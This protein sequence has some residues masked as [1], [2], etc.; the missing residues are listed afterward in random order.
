MPILR[1]CFLFTDIEGSTRLWEHFGSAMPAAYKRHDAILRSV[2]A[3]HGGLVFKVIGDA[4]QVAFSSP[5]DGLNAAHDAQQLLTAAPW[6]VDGLPNPLRVRMALHVASIAPDK[7]GDFRSPELNR[8]GRLLSTAHGGQIVL[9]QGMEA[10]LRGSLPPELTLSDCGPHRLKDLSQPERIFQLVAPGL[11]Q[12]FP[13]L[14][15]VDSRPNNLPTLPTELIGRDYELTAIQSHFRNGHRMVTLLG[16]GGI[17]KTHLALVAG[18]RVL[19]EISERVWFAGLDTARDPELVPSAIATALSISDDG[20]GALIDRIAAYLG[21]GSQM[22]IL[23]NCE[24]VLDAA[25]DVAAHLLGSCPGLVI[26]ATSRTRL[27]I[28]A[29]HI[30]LVEPL[31]MPTASDD[32]TVESLTGIAS[33][34]VFVE[35]AQAADPT[36][37]LTDL[38]ASTVAQICQRL[39]GIPLA[40]ELAAALMHTRSLED[41]YT[42][43]ANRLPVLQE[44]ARDAP[45]RHQTLRD[46][47]LWSYDLLPSDCKTV[48]RYLGV[49][50]GGFTPG[51]AA[52]AIGEELHLDIVAME[53]I[54]TILREISLLRT[55]TGVAG[56][57]MI[58]LETI[59][60][61]SFEQ[62]SG[63]NEQ[64]K[65]RKTHARFVTKLIDQAIHLR[66]GGDE[67]AYT[68]MLG[69]E[70]RNIQ[71]ALDWLISSDPNMALTLATPL[72][73][74]WQIEGHLTEARSLLER[75]TNAANLDDDRERGRAAQAL[76]GIALEQGDF[77]AA[78]EQ[79]TRATGIWAAL[80]DTL[81]L[82]EALRGHGSADFGRGNFPTARVLFKQALEHY[83]AIGDQQGISASLN[84]LGIIAQATGA[85]NDAF[86]LHTESLAIKRDRNDQIGI[87]TSLTNIGQV[88]FAQG[89]IPQAEATLTEALGL[90]RKISDQIGIAILL[91]S[92]GDVAMQ[93]GDQEKARICYQDDLAI[94]LD[95]DDQF[96][97]ARASMSLAYLALLDVDYS[98]ARS[99][100]LT[101]ISIFQACDATP[102]L[103]VCLERVAM[104]RSRIGDPGGALT[105][106]EI[107][108]DARKTAGL[109]MSPVDTVSQQALL[110][111]IG[112]PPG[113]ITTDAAKPGSHAFAAVIDEVLVSLKSESLP[114]CDMCEEI[115]L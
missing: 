53:R 21:D 99:L 1:S 71:T 7:D 33:V 80:D 35:R 101:A 8:L 56:Q 113:S 20:M 89:E 91:S 55:V 65:A 60:E 57:R 106:L 50:I 52:S 78:Q 34:E 22:L 61:F 14:R 81:M 32:G 103:I 69:P 83:R 43:L 66:D 73:S 108:A 51:V 18:T 82:A 36:F 87:V 24:H 13:P 68:A 26:L 64:E 46:T 17:G 39:D 107:A 59:R 79:F 75:A 112:L 100:L 38:T 104:L 49:F 90:A 93:Q 77:L 95:I 84:Q 97:H 27:R 12:V 40:L 110:D 41:I 115:A 4:L 86:A 76:G 6:Q 98:T 72:V 15:S 28:R 25:A 37:E 42:S 11:A 45:K 30:V 114:V 31:A 63:N 29:E 94:C 74:F 19:G 92:L 23:D 3:N 111:E 62:L 96:G 102:E 67:L 9:S 105:L 16:P 44:G 58:M 10:T 2:V 5:I 88:L 54:L 70:R 85:W 47:I 109:A 48:F